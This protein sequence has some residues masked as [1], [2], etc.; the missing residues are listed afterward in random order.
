MNPFQRISEFTED[1]RYLWR[2]DGGRAALPVIA[3]DIVRLPFR[4]L[5]F[6]ILAC[7]LEQPLPG[8]KPQVG[9]DIRIFEQAD[10]EH[11]KEIDRP[12]EARQCARRLKYGQKG[13]VA[14]S[15][16]RVVGYA[17]GCSEVQPEL[18]RVNIEL[19]PGD[20]LCTDVYTAP[21]FRGRGVQTALALAR[22]ELFRE[23]GF[24]RAVCYIEIHNAPSLAVWQRKLQAQMVGSIDF[25]RIGPWYRVSFAETGIN[26]RSVGG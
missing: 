8:I 24:N 2:R 11:V 10:L 1:W 9:L 20:V 5:K 7:S 23:L 26:G 19:K 15:Q 22:F 25:L 12:S 3:Q 17:W 13:L 4:H 6:L 16:G 18:E 21:A 14:L